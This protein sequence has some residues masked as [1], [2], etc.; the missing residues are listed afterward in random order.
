VIYL[1]SSVALAK[2]LTESRA[3]QEAFWNE[4]LISSRLLQ[5]EVW[6]RI[7]SRESR[8]GAEPARALLDR[9]TLIDLSEAILARALK[10]ISG[11]GSH[12]RCS[13][14]RLDRVPGRG[15]VGPWRWRAT[16][17]V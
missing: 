17:N 7:N 12:A 1:D 5:Y 4:T 10:T 6:N 11:S 14:P 16:I 13:P 3:P 8:R 9:V 15:K 2:L